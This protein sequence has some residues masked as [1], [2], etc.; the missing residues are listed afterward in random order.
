MQQAAAE[1]ERALEEWRRVPPTEYQA[2][3]VAAVEKKLEQVRRRLAQTA[4]PEVK[5]R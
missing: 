2:E 5:P 1:W 3:K 4:A